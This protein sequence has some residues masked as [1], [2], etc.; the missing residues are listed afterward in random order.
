MTRRVMALCGAVAVWHLCCLTMVMVCG[1]AVGRIVEVAYTRWRG[2]LQ[3]SYSTFALLATTLA[4][5]ITTTPATVV[6]LLLFE[7][8]TRTSQR[9]SRL[10]LT[11]LGWQAA[12]LAALM[13]S[14]QVGL[15]Y[16][17]NRLDW[18][19]FGPPGSLYGF[20]NLVLPRVI[21]WLV[22]TTPPALIALGLLVGRSVAGP[23]ACL[24]LEKP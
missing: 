23:R 22:C 8:L 4:S 10:V 7:R 2:D 6:S 24:R 3:A 1:H 17:V 11:F 16:R 19:L 20:R 12:V 5:L 18:A 15:A 9:R 21:A 14:Y 13:W